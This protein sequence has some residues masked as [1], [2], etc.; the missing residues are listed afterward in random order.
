LRILIDTHVLL[1][2]LANSGSLT[3][4]ARKLIADPENTIFV[5]A[6]SLWEIWLKVSL[7]KLEVPD[8]FEERLAGETFE[9]LPLTA[10]HARGVAVL[11]WHH[12]DAFDRM[13]L[14]QARADGLTLLTS[15]GVMAAYGDGVILAR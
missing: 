15:D 14:A 5:S 2:W 4:Q 11:P 10:D 7:N 3:K 6:V 9:S 13:L 8:R 1:W 12:R